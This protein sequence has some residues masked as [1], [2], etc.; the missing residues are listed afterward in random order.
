MFITAYKDD[1]NLQQKVITCLLTFYSVVALL[2]TPIELCSVSG[3]G[4][5]KSHRK[6]IKPRTTLE[7]SVVLQFKAVIRSSKKGSESPQ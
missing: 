6:E 2:T 3:V 1:V 7:R 5:P 4:L